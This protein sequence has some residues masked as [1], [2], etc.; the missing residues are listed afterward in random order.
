VPIRKP[1]IHFSKL[2]RQASLPTLASWSIENFKAG[3]V[4]LLSSH[5]QAKESVPSY[6]VLH[7][8]KDA[9]KKSWEKLLFQGD[10]VILLSIGNGWRMFLPVVEACSL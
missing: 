1:I 10:F 3:K 7:N 6:Q 5:T 4:F 9:K 8:G 2:K